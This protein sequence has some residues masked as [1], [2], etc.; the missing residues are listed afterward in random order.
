[1]LARESKILEELT[2]LLAPVVAAWAVRSPLVAA[3]PDADELVPGAAG[4]GMADRELI[5]GV[6]CA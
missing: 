4:A 2:S 1:M 5:G 6:C 3:D